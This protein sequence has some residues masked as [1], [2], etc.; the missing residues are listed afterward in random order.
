L[1]SRMTEDLAMTVFCNP[2]DSTC[3]FLP[4][5]TKDILSNIMAAHFKNLDSDAGL[6]HLN[7][8]LEHASYVDG[9]VPTQADVEVLAAV[10]T[11]DAK[12]YAHI[13][14]WQ[15]HLKSF[16]ANEQHGF[17]A[18]SA[19]GHKGT[20]DHAHEAPAAAPAAAKAESKDED[21]I[22]LFGDEDPE[23]EAEHERLLE[24]RKKEAD[25]RKRA[26]GEAPKKTVIAK[27]SVILEV[28]PW[29]EETDLAEMEKAVRTIEMEGLHWGAAKFVPI[30]YGVKKMQ[31]IATVVDDLVSV[32]DLSDKIQEFEELV[33]SVDIAAFNKL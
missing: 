9:W 15:A 16:S 18:P 14:R 25:D 29:G 27:S 28:K 10:A 6:K 7:T 32:D 19:G 24:A 1:T 22:D 20:H 11:V 12:K 4:P 33:Q 21:E 2:D 3:S 8:H 26:L 30:A 17:P 13:A 31:I 23:K 5:S